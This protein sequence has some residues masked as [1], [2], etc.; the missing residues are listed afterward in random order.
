MI[1][2]KPGRH[3]K[4][5]MFRCSAD[6]YAQKMREHGYEAEVMPIPN[7]FKEDGNWVV[8]YQIPVDKVE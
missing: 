3:A 6:E 5:C 8:V 2:L 7:G 4:V 1:K